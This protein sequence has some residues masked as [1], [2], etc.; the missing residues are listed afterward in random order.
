MRNCRALTLAVMLCLGAGEWADAQLAMLNGR[1]DSTTQSAVIALIDSAVA[2]GLPRAFTTE[3]LVRRA[4]QGATTDAS[5]H[6]IILAVRRRAR[7]LRV[8]ADV[9]RTLSPAELDAAAEALEAGIP[10][11]T[12]E[13]LRQARGGNDITVP[14]VVLVDLLGR[15]LPLDTAA[16]LVL[17][18]AG[19]GLGDHAFLA[20]REDVAKKMAGGTPPRIATAVRTRAVVTDGAAT[21]A[22]G[23]RASIPTATGGGPPPRTPPRPP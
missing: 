6:D 22:P 9:L 1:V 5:S 12:L 18:L 3:R 15:G 7:G 4:L 23:D 10:P 8:A 11:T 2:D 16:T 21:S 20:L 14:A 19:S 13:L 17:A